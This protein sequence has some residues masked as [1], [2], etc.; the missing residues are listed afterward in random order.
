MRCGRGE[1]TRPV[2]QAVQQ[3]SFARC[4]SSH[5]PM[6]PNMRMEWEEEEE[7]GAAAEDVWRLR[8]TLHTFGFPPR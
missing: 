1:A 3:L 4:I 8:A 5:T 7:E 6:M 2:L